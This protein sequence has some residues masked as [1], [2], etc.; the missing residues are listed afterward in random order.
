MTQPRCG[1][2]QVID[3]ARNPAGTGTAG[4]A[5]RPPACAIAGTRTETQLMARVAT[6]NLAARVI[7]FMRVPPRVRVRS[8]A[9]VQRCGLIAL[10][11]TREVADRLH[12]RSGATHR[13]APNPPG[14]EIDRLCAM[15][16]KYTGTSTWLV[17]TGTS[18]VSS[19]LGIGDGTVI[20]ERLSG[21][22]HWSNHPWR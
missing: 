9:D 15:D 17:R 22:V 8:P 4:A 21:D 20:G 19:R 18:R 5:G 14:A 2:S 16:L 1:P 6:T 3:C 10:T 13:R 11:R 12:R 7:R